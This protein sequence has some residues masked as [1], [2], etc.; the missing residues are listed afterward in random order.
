MIQLRINGSLINFGHIPPED[1]N[2]T[3]I[4]LTTPPS[5]LIIRMEKGQ[6]ILIGNYLWDLVQRMDETGVVI[7]NG[8][9]MTKNDVNK[10][11]EK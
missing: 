9:I 7:F 6:N 1:I 4:E 10:Y 3:E 11:K 8:T 2:I 5:H